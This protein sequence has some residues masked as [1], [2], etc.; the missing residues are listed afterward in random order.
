MISIKSVANFFFS[1]VS[2]CGY[3]WQQ[4]FTP[5][6]VHKYY[7]MYRIWSTHRHRE[8]NKESDVDPATSLS[9]LMIYYLFWSSGCVLSQ[10]RAILRSSLIMSQSASNCIDIDKRTTCLKV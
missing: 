3:R 7:Y 5:N 4:L 9:S 6:Y 1:L 8:I 10:Q 2:D